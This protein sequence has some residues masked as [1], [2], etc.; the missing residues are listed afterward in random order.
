MLFWNAFQVQSLHTRNHI[1]LI[2]KQGHPFGLCVTINAHWAM[3][4]LSLWLLTV[5]AAPGEDFTPGGRCLRGN[6]LLL[7]RSCCS[8][9]LHSL[10]CRRLSKY[11][12]WRSCSQVSRSAGSILRQPCAR[13]ERR[14]LTSCHW[15]KTTKKTSSLATLCHAKKMKC[16]SFTKPTPEGVIC[17]NINVLYYMF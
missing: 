16:Q 7:L 17:A 1:A 2:S 13:W 6:L 15:Q 11:G 8:L 3:T 12:C 10:L 9:E 5:C 14:L 4:G